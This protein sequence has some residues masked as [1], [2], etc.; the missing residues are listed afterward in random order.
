MILPPKNQAPG[1]WISSM[2]N[3]KSC[4]RSILN[5]GTETSLPEAE[6]ASQK[7]TKSDASSCWIP[8]PP[9]ELSVEVKAHR[10]GRSHKVPQC[11]SR[12]DSGACRR[13]AD[14]GCGHQRASA[15]AHIAAQFA[16][17]PV[18]DPESEAASK[19]GVIY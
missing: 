3:F 12:R 4:W 9:T 13:S 8:S 14:G 17:R 7:R 10:A 1:R 16:N 19:G 6:A 18:A 15:A 2:P 11:S 5:G